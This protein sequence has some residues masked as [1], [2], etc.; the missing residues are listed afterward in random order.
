MSSIEKAP[1]ELTAAQKRFV[2]KAR[3]EGLKIRWNYSGRCMYGRQ[4][5]AVVVSDP[6]DFP[7]K[8]ASID[9]MGRDYVVYVS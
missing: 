9:N 7:F 3:R 5:P 1:Y 4:C 8:N 6:K 2:S